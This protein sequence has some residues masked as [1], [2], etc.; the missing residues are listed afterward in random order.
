MMSV[1]NGLRL[2]GSRNTTMPLLA[3]AIYS[4]GVVAGEIDQPVVD[5][6]GL[7]GR[8]DFTVEYAAGDNDLL[9]RAGAPPPDAQPPDSQGAPFLSAVREQ[10]GLKLVS[11]KGTIKTLII[12]HVEK[13][14]EN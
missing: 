4:T 1:R 3:E 7:K 10:L 11:S 2:F 8:F 6:T 13:P 14:S 12:D 9:R 5:Q